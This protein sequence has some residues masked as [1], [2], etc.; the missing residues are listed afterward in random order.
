METIVDKTHPPGPPNLDS[1]SQPPAEQ[2]VDNA[3]TLEKQPALPAESTPSSTAPPQHN[4]NS[5]D[6]FITK[7][8][9]FLS[10]ATSE[11]LGGIGVGLAA[12]TYVVLGKLGLILIGAFGTEVLTRLGL[13]KV[14]EPKVQDKEEEER[15][16]N[17]FDDF[18]PGIRE[19][20]GGFVDAVIR[21]YVKWWYSPILPRD[22]SFPLACRRVFNSFLLSISNALYRKRPAD[23]FLDLLTNSSSIFIVY[24]DVPSDTNLTAADAV[25]NYLAENPDSSLANLLSQPQQ[26]AKFPEWR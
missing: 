19:A 5:E 8:L 14:P 9:K 1:P 26:A 24:A 10:T 12:A 20:L 22:S 17:T 13:D 15:A 23:A 2:T 7:G 3:T 11:T 4:I 25:Y 18:K 16:I 21:D 6:D